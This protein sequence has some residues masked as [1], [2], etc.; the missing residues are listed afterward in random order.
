MK[1]TLGSVLRNRREA[2]R[3]SQRELARRLD[4]KASHVGYLETGK[5]RPSL[6]LLG[7]LASVLGLEREPL[8][9]LAHPEAKALL[10][11][12]QP[13]RAARPDHA[14][15][16]FIGDKSLLLRNN[17]TKRELRVLSQVKTLGIVSS[18][19]HFI[20]IL[21]AMRQAMDEE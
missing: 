13:D 12:P 5:R 2:M 1:K 6:P 21:N 17:V 7:R 10:E 11:R 18:P 8:F 20:F 14:W 3:L 16:S 19:R 15:R 4:V 9:L